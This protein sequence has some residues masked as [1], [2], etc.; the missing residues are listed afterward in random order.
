MKREVLLMAKGKWVNN[1]G[2]SLV[3]LII[4]IAIMAILAGAIAPAVIRYIRKA[5][6]SRA[7]DEARVIVQAVEAALATKAGE[8]A[9]LVY[10]MTFVDSAGN[11]VSVGLVTNWILSETQSG[12]VFQDTDPDYPNYIIAQEILENLSSNV[13]HD[14]QFFNFTG[15]NNNPIGMNCSQFASAYNNCPGVIVVY[16][17]N[18]KVKMME[19][20]NYGCLI[21]YEDNEYTYLEDET[22]FI[23][24]SRLQ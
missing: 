24:S 3:E 18:G 12:T 4:V 6:A 2:F 17:P 9:P 11:S 10:N 8:D 14:Y 7:T 19:Y 23:S 1:K 20:Y 5:R 22:N 16:T 15:N 21:H 13:D